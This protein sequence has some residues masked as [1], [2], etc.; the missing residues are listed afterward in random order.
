MVFA[1][2]YGMSDVTPYRQILESLGNAVLLFDRDQRLRYLNPAGEMLLDTSAAKALG[3][4]AAILFGSLG[5]RLARDLEATVAGA[6]PRVERHLPLHLGGRTQTVH[7]ALTPVFEGETVTGVVAE[8]E[9]VEN[10][11]HL[12]RDTQLQTQQA[13]V[14]Q[15][16]R[17]LA[18]EIKNPLGG[19][20]GAAQLLAQ[21][22]DSPRL[23]EYTDVIIHEADRLGTLIDRLLAPHRPPR[24]TR[25]NIHQ[26]LERVRQILQAE[27]PQLQLHGDYDPSLPPLAG[28]FD[29]LIQVFLN[30]ARNAAQAVAGKGEVT[31]RTRIEHRLTIRGRL[32]RLVLR[33]DIIDDGPGI[34]P[35]LSD[36]IFYPMITGKADGTGLG[37][38][39]AQALVTR[40][41]GVIEH[42]SRPGQ[43]CFSVY[44]P[45]ED[46][47][48]P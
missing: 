14:N 36:H 9:T 34:P 26:V 12:S 23:R 29:Q 4:S 7:C 5:E 21:E 35:A 38:S 15:L 20:R 47:R 10:Y 46:S 32:H 42:R 19:L 28:D 25:L 22:L 16:L 33:V 44:L 8:I 31:L 6:A 40:H 27:Y 24:I 1:F 18:H 41:G 43:T 37:L 3:Q 30:I 17:G 13:A 2:K 39:I 45:L 11:S 48:E